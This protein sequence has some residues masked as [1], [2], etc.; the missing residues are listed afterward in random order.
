MSFFNHEMPIFTRKKTVFDGSPAPGIW[1]LKIQINDRILISSSYT[2]HDQA[3]L[4]WGAIAAVIFLS[5]Q[6]LPLNWTMQTLFAA[7]LTCLG[8]VGMF[9]LT[10]EFAR[11]ERLSWVLASWAGLM[12]FGAIATYQSIFGGWTWALIHICPIWLGLSGCG[13]LATG[14]GM[15][16]RLFLLLS[17]PH[18]LAIPLLPL[19]PAW[20][21]LITGSVI[22]LSAFFIAE[23]QWDANGVCEYQKV[24]TVAIADANPSPVHKRRQ[25]EGSGLPATHYQ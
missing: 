21:P 24:T 7:T 3:C 11:F 15:R 14:F 13:Y 2:R 16:S 5:A 10:W 23:L 8:I 6:F 18:L 17:V 19:F 4:L 9:L 25:P 22:S 1:L 20:N 12:L